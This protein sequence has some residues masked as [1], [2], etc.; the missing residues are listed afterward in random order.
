[1]I[2]SIGVFRRIFKVIKT[3]FYFLL[4]SFIN[5][6][7]IFKHIFPF[8]LSNLVKEFQLKFSKT[9]C[10]IKSPAKL[11][12][13]SRHCTLRF[14][15]FRLTFLFEGACIEI[16]VTDKK[17]TFEEDVKKINFKETR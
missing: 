17:L 6:I 2:K 3:I 11:P 14:L 4:I 16:I 10:D 1:M 7:E 15:S 8:E 12:E 9:F 5:I 13:S